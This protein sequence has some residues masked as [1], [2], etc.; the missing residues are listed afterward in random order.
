MVSGSERGAWCGAVKR[1]KDGLGVGG[2]QDVIY[3]R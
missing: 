3:C 1:N 2:R